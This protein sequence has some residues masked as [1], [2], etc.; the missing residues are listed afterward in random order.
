MRIMP[1][2]ITRINTIG[3]DARLLGFALLI[4]L[5]SEIFFG[6]APALQASKVGLTEPLKKSGRGTGGEDKGR[7]RARHVGCE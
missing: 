6:L 1:V 4:S 7:L 2:D 5:L 3:L